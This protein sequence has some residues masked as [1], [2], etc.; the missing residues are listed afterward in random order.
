MT[1]VPTRYLY[2]S[3][4][5][6]LNAVSNVIGTPW[7]ILLVVILW[8]LPTD[9]PLV[10]GEP[11][12]WL[13]GRFALLPGLLH[14]RV[15]GGLVPAPPGPSRLEPSD[16]IPP[17]D[18]PVGR[19]RNF[20]PGKGATDADPD[21]WVGAVLV[22]LGATLAPSSTGDPQ[23]TTVNDLVYTTVGGVD[24]RLDLAAPVVGPGPFPAVIVFYGGAWRTG[25]KWGNR[26][27]LAEFARRGFVAIAPAVSP[28]PG[29]PLPG[30]GPRRQGGGPLAP[31]A[32][33]RLP[34]R[35]DQVG[36]MGYSAGAHLSLMLGAT[37]PA[38]GL[39]G[40]APADAPSTRIQAVVNYFGPTDLAATDISPFSQGLVRDFLGASA[41]D[42]P[43]L[44]AS[45]SPLTYVDRT[46]P[47]DLD[48]PRD[49]RLRGPGHAGD[50]LSE[51][52]TR[53]GVPG[54]TELLSGLGHGW[55]GAAM[56][57]TMEATYAFFARNSGRS[58]GRRHQVRAG[59]P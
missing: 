37:G 35:P 36:A 27:V 50:R 54:R 21:R 3:L 22:L 51:A 24:L 59:S 11:T 38:D 56:N 29:G 39:E 41:A 4:P 12:W 46:D 57:R 13:G 45:A 34:D 1:F 49:G 7:I 32:R 33:G 8:R 17:G 47:A 43:K 16:P 25:N 23:I 30:A 5:G 58:S 14:D 55:T 15:V 2:P 48:L 53:A 6:R 44:A 9:A 31:G 52:M 40:D 28:L 42:Q 18:D 26:P 19:V 20:S 10:P